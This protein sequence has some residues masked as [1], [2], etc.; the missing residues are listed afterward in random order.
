MTFVANAENLTTPAVCYTGTPWTADSGG[1]LR[2]V[3]RGKRLLAAK[4]LAAGDFRAEFDLSLE[5]PKREMALV[6]G[7]DSELKFAAGAASWELRGRFFRAADRPVVVAAPPLRAGQRFKVT[8]ERLG[9]EVILAVEGAVI[10]RGACSRAE[11]GTIGLDPGAG[12]VS[13]YG[14]SARGIF[15]A[16][17]RV[18]KPFGNPFGMQLHPV[19]VE[20]RAVYAP[21]LLREAPTNES[22]M[23]RRSDGALENH[24][25]YETGQRFRECDAVQGWRTDLVRGWSRVGFARQG[26]LPR[27]R[28]WRRTT[29]QVHVVV[30][31]AG[32]GT[33]GY[34]GRLYEVSSRVGCPRLKP[35]EPAAACCSRLC[36]FDPWLH[37]AAVG[38]NFAGRGASHP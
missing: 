23:I 18:P 26:I 34:R 24:P 30:H 33:G 29:E 9:A 35:V 1:F 36:W 13:L 19:P 4:P 8:L 20:S 16:E 3:G 11:L 6:V 7:P 22:S 38:S 37:P 28:P 32:E 15:V 17:E 25:G 27:C 21:V 31:V 12:T 5:A 14:F 10:Y 2:G